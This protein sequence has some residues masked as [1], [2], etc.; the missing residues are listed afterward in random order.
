MECNWMYMQEN[1]WKCT[2]EYT[3]RYTWECRESEIGS[4]Q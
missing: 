4:I 1:A 2:R 3:L